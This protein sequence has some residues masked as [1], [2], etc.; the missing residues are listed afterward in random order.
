[1][2]LF[3][4]SLSFRPRAEFFSA[5]ADA[6]VITSSQYRKSR[7]QLFLKIMR[8]FRVSLQNQP[9]YPKKSLGLEA[10]VNDCRAD[11]E[12]RRAAS[13][14]ALC[15]RRRRTVRRQCVAEG[16]SAMHSPRV[17]E[18]APTCVAE[19]GEL[20][21]TAGERTSVSVTRG[22]CATP[23]NRRRRR[24]TA[25]TRHYISRILSTVRG[26]C[27]ADCLWRRVHVWNTSN[28]AASEDCRIA[29]VRPLRGRL[30]ERLRHPRVTL[31]SPAVKHS[32]P[33][34]ATVAGAVSHVRYK[35]RR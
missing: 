32:S 7:R 22:L 21:L 31:R 6:K 26:L 15:S 19:G 3:Q 8:D 25:P 16:Q 33:P 13:R 29:L 20:C 28:R 1:M 4:R 23:C 18:T 24:R 35:N 9:L 11:F 5:K 17:S 30:I 12:L 10:A 14:S 2:E 34:S 27:M